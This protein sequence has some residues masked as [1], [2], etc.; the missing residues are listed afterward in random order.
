MRWSDNDVTLFAGDHRALFAHLRD[1]S[2]ISLVR[3][4]DG[5][6]SATLTLKAP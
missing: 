3:I 1:G 5:N 2:A 4:T 6:V